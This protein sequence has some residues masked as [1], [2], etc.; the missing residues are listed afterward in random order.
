VLEHDET[1][2]HVTPGRPKWKG[3]VLETLAAYCDCVENYCFRDF[4]FDSDILDAF[5]GVINSFS[6]PLGDFH[7]GLP[8]AYFS[9]ALLW[10]LSQTDTGDKTRRRMEFPSW[11]WAGR[12]RADPTTLA[13]GIIS[14][15]NGASWVRTVIA[16]YNRKHCVDCTTIQ[17]IKPS[18]QEH[19]VEEQVLYTFKDVS[20]VD[21]PQWLFNMH[22]K[23]DDH[24]TH[25]S[26]LPD[27]KPPLSHF[28]CFITRL[29]RLHLKPEKERTLYATKYQII[30]PKNDTVIGKIWLGHKVIEKQGLELDFVA[31][32]EIDDPVPLGQTEVYL[33]AVE[34][35]HGFSYRIEINDDPV[36]GEDWLATDFQWRII[37]LG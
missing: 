23:I 8:V 29:A 35:L 21:L 7:W 10:S 36:R 22:G 20:R 27:P 9:P 16:F 32:A 6:L 24:W 19:S 5:K 2:F 14:P 26:R 18:V 25:P 33:M 31:I 34:W 13:N 1:T 28:L 3:R 12:R 37:N 11:S 17:P 4:S 15:A 30:D